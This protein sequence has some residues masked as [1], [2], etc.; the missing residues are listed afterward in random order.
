MRALAFTV[1]AGLGLLGCSAPGWPDREDGLAWPK[2]QSA[3]RIL[4]ER[5]AKASTNALGSTTDIAVIKSAI[6]VSEPQGRVTDIRWLSPTLVMAKVRLPESAWYYVVEKR[7][8]EWLI[9][10]CYLKWIS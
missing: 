4:D 10:T 2:P 9:R 3:A 6:A 1:V 7:R 8:K 5:F